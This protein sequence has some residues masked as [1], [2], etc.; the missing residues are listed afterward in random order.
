MVF[1]GSAFSSSLAEPSM[2]L[3]FKSQEDIEMEKHGTKR[4]QI[5]IVISY[6]SLTCCTALIMAIVAA[7]TF[8]VFLIV[9]APF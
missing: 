4:L 8:T 2:I 1:K 3:F 7:N 6:W 5:Q 9:K